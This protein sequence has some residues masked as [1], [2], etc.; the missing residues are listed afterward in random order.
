MRTSILLFGL[1]FASLIHPAHTAWAQ[2]PAASGMV[3]TIAGTGAFG[4]I[5]DGG[6]A[7]NASLVTVMSLAVDHAR[8][9]SPL[10]AGGQFERASCAPS[11]QSAA[12]A[13]RCRGDLHPS[14][15]DQRPKT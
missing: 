7:T 9:A 8:Q 1:A 14:T 3:I 5:G 11:S 4:L 10:S 12:V 6:P 13:H 2:S 15:Q